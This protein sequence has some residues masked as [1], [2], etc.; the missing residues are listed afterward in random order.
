VD[1]K[2]KSYIELLNFAQET[3]ERAQFL[4]FHEMMNNTVLA[5]L[6]DR[7]ITGVVTEVNF[8]DNFL[9]I[10]AQEPLEDEGFNQVI[11]YKL[12]L[13]MLELYDLKLI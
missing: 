3:V 13:R 6:G 8:D 4:F 10:K 7:V 2:V 1:A 11:H 12:D 9:E 5:D